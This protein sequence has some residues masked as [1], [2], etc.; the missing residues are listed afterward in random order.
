MLVFTDGSSEH[1]P[2]IGWVGGYVYSEE[3]VELSNFVPLNM[4]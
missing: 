2:T 4:K 3:G 1:V